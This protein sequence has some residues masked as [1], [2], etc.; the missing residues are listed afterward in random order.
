M[1]H[2]SEKSFASAKVAALQR[3]RRGTVFAIFGL[4]LAL[5]AILTPFSA[6]AGEA[7]TII[8]QAEDGTIQLP[9][10]LVTIHGRTVRYE[11]QPHKNTIGYWTKAEDWVSWDFTLT[12]PSAFTVT[13]TQACGKN[14][15]G[16]EY[17]VAVGDQVLTDVVP[18]TGAFTNFVERVIG[19]VKL[20]QAGSYTL[21]VKPIKKPGLAV[22]DLRAVTLKRKGEVK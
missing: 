11:P 5:I 6:T 3:D 9:A 14:S 7:P 16:S 17:Q 13:V 1:K 19:T 2:M 8:V 22:M 10:R 12:R 18:E 21:S 4:C 20:P 15:G